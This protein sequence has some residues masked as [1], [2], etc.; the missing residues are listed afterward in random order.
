MEKNFFFYIEVSSI[1]ILSVSILSNC[2][3]NY[4][5]FCIMYKILIYLE[6]LK[7]RFENLKLKLVYK[8]S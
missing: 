4:M 8:I 1:C 3:M 2:I 6:Y 7:T 5:I